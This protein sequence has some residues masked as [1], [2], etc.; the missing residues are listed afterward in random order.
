M[1]PGPDWLSRL[2]EIV[3]VTGQL[4]VRCAF[5]APWHVVYEQSAARE[6]P[7]HV[8]VNGSALLEDPDTRTS[9]TLSSGD[10]LLLPHGS[11]HVLHDGSGRPPAPV[12]VTEG[13]NIILNENIGSG[14][15]LDMLCGRFFVEPPH[16]RLVRDYLPTTLIVRAQNAVRHAESAPA[17]DQLASL[18]RMMRV[19]AAGEKLG[20]HAM[21]NVLSSALFALTLRAASE[22]QRTPKGLLALAGHPRL[23]PAVMAMFGDPAKPWT[24]PELAQ[25]CNMS[26]ATFVRHFE[27]ALGRSAH[28]LLT[29]IRMSL[30]ANA[31]KHPSVTTE[32]AAELAGFQSIAAFR[33]SFAQW[34][35]VTPGEWRRAARRSEAA[36]SVVVE[37]A[38]ARAS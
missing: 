13:P 16:D 4:E 37:D 8:I 33:R 30:A 22:S 14:A 38:G 34:M 31:L 19:E 5:G 15:R 12:S 1:R 11:A 27:D 20:S 29:D 28:D 18:V 2:L 25:L 36:G 21:L 35:G 6:I 9:Q 26:R 24:L 32:A 10:I 3:T 7:Y 17:A 23:A